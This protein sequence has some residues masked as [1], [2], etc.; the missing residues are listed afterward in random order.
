VLLGPVY[1]EVGATLAARFTSTVGLCAQ[2]FLRQA[3]ADGRV[4]PLPPR[5][6]DA[7]PL[8][9]RVSV[10]FLSDEDLPAGT[11]VPPAWLEAVPLTVITAGRHGARLYSRGRWSRVPAHPSR[12][13]DPTGAGDSFAAAFL[14][15]LDEGVDPVEAARFAAVVASFTIES[16]GPQSPTREQVE[17]R[18][19]GLE[20]VLGDATP[21]ST[22]PRVAP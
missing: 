19:R 5:E 7:A 6:W 3:G 22:G 11:G 16:V 15:A 18:R 9:A 12:E 20:F 13:V 21:S 1:H 10:L 4:S 2:G 8:L 14:V 17:L